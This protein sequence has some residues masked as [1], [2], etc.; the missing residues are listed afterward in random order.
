MFKTA[1]NMSARTKDF[2]IYSIIYIYGNCIEVKCALNKNLSI[3]INTINTF[4][5]L[6]ISD[7]FNIPVCTICPWFFC[8]SST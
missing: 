1:F 4:T 5:E 6:I 8:F 2:L 3:I 7:W